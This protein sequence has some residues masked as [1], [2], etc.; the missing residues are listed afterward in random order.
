[1]FDIHG[2]LP[3][4]NRGFSGVL[5][6]RATGFEPVTFVRPLLK[7]LGGDCGVTVLVKPAEPLGSAPHFGELRVAKVEIRI[8][9]R[10]PPSRVPWCDVR[11][12]LAT[13]L[14]WTIGQSPKPYPKDFCPHCLVS[15]GGGR[16][17]RRRQPS[18]FGRVIHR[19]QVAA[20]GKGLE[21]T[22]D[23]ATSVNRPGVTMFE[24]SFPCYLVPA[25]AALFSLFD[26]D[27]AIQWGSVIIRS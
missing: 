22:F 14:F 2:L 23:P 26:D 18:V 8:L 9:S 24:A 4:R 7:L 5:F 20:C 16:I 6:P 15:I 25:G 19:H 21:F 12:P 3:S 27:S 13:G 1:M 17:K 11:N 10:R